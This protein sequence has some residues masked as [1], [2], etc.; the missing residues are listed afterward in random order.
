MEMQDTQEK[1]THNVLL[2]DSFPR[3]AVPEYGRNA[4]KG[5]C[6][7]RIGMYARKCLNIVQM[8]AGSAGIRYRCAH[9]MCWNTIEMRAPAGVRDSGNAR[10]PRWNTI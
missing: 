3:G 7:E 1:C 10:I 5:K 2:L 6:W 4:H 8:H 9:A